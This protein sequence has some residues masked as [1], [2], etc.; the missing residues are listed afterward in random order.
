[1]NKKTILIVLVLVCIIAIV[2][3]IY[4]SRV[5]ENSNITSPIH[6][7]ALLSLTG[8]A[9]A[10]GENSKKAIQLAVNEINQ[11]G[12]VR[13]RK[14]EVDY[15]DTAGDS[16]KAVSAYQEA[17][18]IDHADAI[19]GPL[20]QNE[21]VSVLPLV[22]QY[23]TPTIIPGY[24]PL[25]NRKDHSNPLII[26][27]DAQAEAGQMA[28]YLY[29]KGIRRVAVVGTLDIWE[30]TVSKA[31]A[32][33][34]TAFGGI[35]TDQEIVQSTS[36]D[37]KFPIAKAL[38]TKPEAVFLGTY[39]QFVHSTKELHNLGFTGGVFGIEVDDYLAG[40]TYG[41]SKGLQFIAPD[42]YTTNFVTKFTDTYGTKPGLPAG[43]SYDATNIL[44]TLID[45][46]GT[47]KEALLGAMKEF[48]SYDGVAG[49]LK[50]LS[51]DRTSLPSAIFEI[52]EKGVI[53]KVQT[54]E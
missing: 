2:V 13:G 11:K 39:Y 18:N 7:S 40:E 5:Q 33:K 3:R 12:G 29:D 32:E 42:L 6:I 52:G 37:M 46:V 50:I 22:Q 31:F 4:N 9:S 44:F 10:W 47:D 19:I 15:Q 27:M 8:D 43:Q 25:E 20:Q 30:T 23:K 49:K 45:K 24:I 17:V 1:M 16:K 36:A 28:K 14:I 51:D 53:Q 48:K 41:W 54:I 35:V 34:F 21:G 38:G 26:W